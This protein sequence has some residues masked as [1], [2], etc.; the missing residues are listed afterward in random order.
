M[1]SMAN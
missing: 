1:S